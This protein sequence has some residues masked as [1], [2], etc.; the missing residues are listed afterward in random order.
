M[1]RKFWECGSV[2]PYRLTLYHIVLCV[3]PL[4]PHIMLCVC[5]FVVVFFHISCFFY[6]LNS[7]RKCLPIHYTYENVETKRQRETTKKR[8][9]KKT[10]HSQIQNTFSTIVCTCTENHSVYYCASKFIHKIS[11]E[12]NNTSTNN[13][14]M[15]TKTNL[16]MRANSKRNP[17]ERTNKPHNNLIEFYRLKHDIDTV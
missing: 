14:K 12:S 9:K 7:G 1:S 6:F 11:R 5:A 10:I 15:R 3:L 4:F 2:V 13:T 17:T 8:E 16:W